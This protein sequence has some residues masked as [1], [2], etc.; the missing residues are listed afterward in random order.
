MMLPRLL[1]RTSKPQPRRRASLLHPE[2]P[3]EQAVRSPD[4]SVQTC[5]LQE[6]W[7]RPPFIDDAALLVAEPARLRV[8]A[9]NE[10]ALRRP[11]EALRERFGDALVVEAPTVRYAHGAPVLEPF[12][13]VLVTGPSQHSAMLQDDLARRQATIVRL[14]HRVGMMVLE[15]EAPLGHLLGYQD[16]LE[17]KFAGDVDASTW[18][19]RYRPIGDD[20]HAA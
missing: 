14:D 6:I 1:M 10:P 11:V 2:C 17:E 16:W 13:T 5:L 19:S 15:A 3:I 20:P 4:P 18:L 7:R 9:R 12:M 8:L